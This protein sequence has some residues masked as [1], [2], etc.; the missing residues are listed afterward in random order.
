MHALFLEVWMYYSAMHI[1]VPA[2]VAIPNT[3]TQHT[4]CPPPSLP[5]LADAYMSGAELAGNSG[6]SMPEAYAMK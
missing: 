3:R 1:V 4:K 6:T 5:Q 2:Q